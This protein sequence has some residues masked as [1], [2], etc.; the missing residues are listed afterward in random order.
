MRPSREEGAGA[1]HHVVP[2]GNGRRPIVIDDRD[3]IAFVQRFGAIRRQLGWIDH[4][5]CLMDTH[6]HSVVETAEPNLGR[7]MQRL[8]GGH[9][10]WMSV[11]HGTEGSTFSPHFWSRRIHGDEWLLRAC[12]YV[13]VNPVAAGLCDHPRDWRWCTYRRTAGGDPSSYAP[14]E[15]RVL[16]MFGASPREARRRYVQ[17]IDD[18]VANV[19]DGRHVEPVRLWRALGEIQSIR[20]SM[21]SD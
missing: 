7:G 9:S 5:S 14:G 3:R 2:Q 6:L 20:P 17:V 12:L 10:R 18:V 19:I 8:L 4:A 13:V 21:V 11:R 1:I 15:A 16:G